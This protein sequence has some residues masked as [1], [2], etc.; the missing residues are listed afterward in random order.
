MT[1]AFKENAHDNYLMIEHHNII[2]I[3]FKE[4][5][6]LKHLEAFL[7]FSQVVKIE[8]KETTN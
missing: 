4:I 2:F 6:F 3:I 1:H 8:R 5:I 7:T